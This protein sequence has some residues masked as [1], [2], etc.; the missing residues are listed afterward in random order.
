MTSYLLVGY[1]ADR[2]NPDKRKS[3]GASKKRESYWYQSFDLVE[4][5][6][7]RRDSHLA[8]VWSSLKLSSAYNAVHCVT[9]PRAM[10]TLLK[11]K[12]KT[13]VEKNP[14]PTSQAQRQARVITWSEGQIMQGM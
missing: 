6:S 12:L 11:D 5:G 2:G 9:D 13:D 4:R 3:K 7:Q 8:N 10:R 14:G 1:R